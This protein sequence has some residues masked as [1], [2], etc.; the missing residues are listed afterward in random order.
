MAEDGYTKS[1]LHFDGADE[2]VTFTDES[3]KTWTPVGSANIETTAPKFGT[4]SGE[5]LGDG[6]VYCPDHE[7][8]VFGDGDFSIDFW[9]K[10]TGTASNMMPLTKALNG[11]NYAP[12]CVFKANGSLALGFH[13]SS[14]GASWDLCNDVTIGTLASGVWSHVAICRSGVNVYCFLD[15]ALGS[16]TNIGAATLLANGQAA[17]IG[18]DGTYYHSTSFI[19]ELRICKGIARWTSGFTPPETAY[20]WDNTIEITLPLLALE[21]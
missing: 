16:T 11:N 7:D 6:G 18:S 13:A 17:R 4:A 1:L 5:F 3:G 8:F 19:D 12:F 14:G 20:E 15:G 10:I 9:I 21:I 2:S